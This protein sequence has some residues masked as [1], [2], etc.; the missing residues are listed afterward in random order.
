MRPGIMGMWGVQPPDLWEERERAAMQRD[1]ERFL[2]EWERDARQR[3]E[4][5]EREREF[6]TTIY[7]IRARAYNRYEN[8][9]MFVLIFVLIY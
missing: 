9:F 2:G 1:R 6:E 8:V 7:A 4:R 3:E 5:E